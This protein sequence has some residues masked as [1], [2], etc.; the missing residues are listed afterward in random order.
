MEN[1]ADESSGKDNA[2]CGSQLDDVDDSKD[3]SAFSVIENLN[4]GTGKPSLSVSESFNSCDSEDCLNLTFSV[5]ENFNSGDACAGVDIDD[6]AESHGDIGIYIGVSEIIDYPFMQTLVD[7]DDREA[8]VLNDALSENNSVIGEMKMRV[9]NGHENK[10]MMRL[11]SKSISSECNELIDTSQFNANMLDIYGRVVKTGAYNFQ[12]ARIPIPSG[13]NI[14]AWR[15][16]LHDYH[17]NRIV[18]YLEF[19][20]PSSFVHSAPLMSTFKNHQSGV[21][22]SDHVRTYLQVELGINAILGPFVSP[23]VVPLHLSPIMT[24]PKKES[25]IRRIV[26]DLSWLRGMSINDGIPVNE[27]LGS[28]KDLRLPTVDYMANRVRDLGTGCLMYKL[29][30]SRGYRQLRLDP[31]DWPLMSIQNDGQYYMDVC[32]PFGLRTAAMIMERTTL[33]ASHIHGLHG[34]L[35]KP[36][37]DDFGGAELGTE[38]ANKAY[39]ALHT[40]LD[41]L[42]LQLAPHKSCEPSPFM[43][44]LG[45]LINSM[46]MTLSIPE[47][48]LHE[49][50]SI[51][52]S[53]N[54]RMQQPDVKYS[55]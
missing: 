55:R 1:V 34:F 31:W 3:S 40:V 18:D 23:P 43:I 2:D 35:S 16:Y 45:I 44:W 36:Y 9:D 39:D 25:E 27:Y 26:V 21:E 38:D 13:L 11:K 52:S 33:A 49:V 20:W 12:A 42:G 15:E 48:K 19:G 32:P 5:S 28:P 22:Y 37:I 30:L 4:G 47:A 51:V 10:T 54:L 29:D 17:D 53:F 6:I 8:L 24:R 50:Q 46:D 7:D 41:E 14:A